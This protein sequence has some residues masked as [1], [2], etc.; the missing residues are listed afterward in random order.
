MQREQSETE[1]LKRLQPGLVHKNIFM[2]T[3]TGRKKPMIQNEWLAYPIEIMHRQA[4]Q[5]YTKF[6]KGDPTLNRD[7]LSFK[8]KIL[9]S[10]LSKYNQIRSLVKLPKHIFPLDIATRLTIIERCSILKY[11]NS[12]TTFKKFRIWVT[13]SSHVLDRGKWLLVTLKIFE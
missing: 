2:W 3:K 5:A 4:Q 9:I 7:L 11:A 12:I 13:S 8:K 10:A 6:I 1:I